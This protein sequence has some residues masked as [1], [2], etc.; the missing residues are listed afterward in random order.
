VGLCAVKKE[1]NKSRKVGKAQGPPEVLPSGYNFFA[2][3]RLCEKKKRN[4]NP[5]RPTY[6]RQVDGAGSRNSMGQ[7]FARRKKEKKGVDPSLL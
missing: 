3:L 4:K 2:S 5:P 7:V 6:R 1:K